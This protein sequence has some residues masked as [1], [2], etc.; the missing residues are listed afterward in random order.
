VPLI[1][2]ASHPTGKLPP[3][4]WLSEPDTLAVVAALTADGADV[5]FVGGCVRDSLARRPV[6]DIDIATP[7]RPDKV[8]E[9]LTASAIRAVPTGI[10]HGTVSAVTDTRTIEIT[11]LRRDV[12]TDGRHAKVV[13]TDDWVEDAKRRDFTINAMS[14]TPDGDVFDPFEGI[15]DLAHGRIRF[16]G[17]AHERVEEDYLRIL[18]FFRFYGSFGRPPIDTDA[19]AACRAGAEGLKGLSG[20]RIRDELFKILIVPEPADIVIRMRGEGVLEQVLPE[21][22]EINTL[23]L[24]NW[25]EIR[26]TNLCSIAPDA[27]RHLASLLDGGGADIDALAARLK[28]S[29]REKSRLSDLRAPRNMVSPDMGTLDE[30]KLLRHEGAE[31]F[32]DLVLLGWAR[33]MATE[34]RLPGERKQS[35]LRMLEDAETWQPPAF[36]LTGRDVRALGI[37]EGPL[38]GEL[39]TRVEVWWENGDYKAGRQACLDRLLAETERSEP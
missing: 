15:G 29:N 27:V 32:R 10:D 39:L 6:G 18:R 1:P 37:A 33:E 31:L 9:L 5:R 35:W 23:R 36:P 28:L 7:D 2:D 16:V 11:T 20:E 13:F 12:E 24:V 4:T 22:C 3:D 21:A 8:I 17:L 19:L 26:A 14:A 30:K 34:P 38:I 25:L